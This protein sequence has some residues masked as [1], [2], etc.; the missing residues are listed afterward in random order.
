M[1]DLR[2]GPEKNIFVSIGYLEQLIMIFYGGTLS[3][4]AWMSGIRTHQPY[5]PFNGASGMF[6]PIY[7]HYISLPM[8][9]QN[10]RYSNATYGGGTWVY[11][12]LRKWG[13]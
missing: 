1:H 6:S 12:I 13:L 8:V 10:Y 2:F 11:N 7:S 4:V 3:S 9:R 5:L